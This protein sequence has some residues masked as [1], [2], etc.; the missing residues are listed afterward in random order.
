GCLPKAAFRPSSFDHREAAAPP[1]GVQV[2]LSPD[3]K[4]SSPPH[5]RLTL[6][7]PTGRSVKDAP[8]FDPPPLT[9]CPPHLAPPGLPTSSRSIP[10]QEPSRGH[11]WSWPPSSRPA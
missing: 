7:R 6:G 3:G 1:D 5:R 8:P 11:R 2:S 9:S 4:R 10:S